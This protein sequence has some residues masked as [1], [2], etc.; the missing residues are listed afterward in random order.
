MI[1]SQKDSPIPS[2]IALYSVVTS[3]NAPAPLNAS[4]NA[5]SH[6]V[7]KISC[8]PS[9]R[10]SNAALAV[11][12]PAGI[13]PPNPNHVDVPASVTVSVANTAAPYPLAV[14]T[15]AP[16]ERASSLACPPALNPINAEDPHSAIVIAR[17]GAPHAAP[18][19][20][21]ASAIVIGIDMY[22]TVVPVE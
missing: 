13:N 3:S 1:A 12:L 2:V 17:A 8:T 14:H 20:L 19:P 21:V 6:P 9:P 7:W 5:F 18:I 15:S 4:N 16:I 10:I 11:I 22:P